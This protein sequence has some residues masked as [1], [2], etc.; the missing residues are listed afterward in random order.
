MFR[1]EEAN[2]PEGRRRQPDPLFDVAPDDE[3]RMMTGDPI[4]DRQPVDTTNKTDDV[5]GAPRRERLGPAGRMLATIVVV[6]AVGGL[7]VGALQWLR[8]DRDPVPR[9]PGWTSLVAVDRASGDLTHLS[10][11]NHVTMKRDFP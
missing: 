4:V 3:T 1:D 5:D 2:A 8:N 9:T 10:K 7:S 6:A 11:D